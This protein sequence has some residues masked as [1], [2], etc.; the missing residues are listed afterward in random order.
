MLADQYTDDE[1]RSRMMGIA[2]GGLAFG[3]LGNE[4]EIT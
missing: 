1:E 4:R 3:V 2:L